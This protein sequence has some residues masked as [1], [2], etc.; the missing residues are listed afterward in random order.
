MHWLR[1]PS[2]QGALQDLAAGHGP[3]THET[4]DRLQPYGTV[5]LIRA[6]L[7]TAGAIPPRDEQL[8]RLEDQVLRIAARV[9]DPG[10]RR[11]VRSFA[12]WHHLRRLRRRSQPASYE[13]INSARTE[14]KAAAELVNWLRQHGTTLADCRQHDIDEWLTGTAWLRVLARTFLAWAV[15]NRH[16]QKVKIPARQ[17]RLSGA[18][19]HTDKRWNL[20]RRLLHD[21]TLD[22]RDRVAGLILL[23]FAQP[24]TRISTLTIDQIDD[25]GVLLTLTLGAEPI[26]IPPPLDDLLRA[27]RDRRQGHAA[28]GRTDSNPWLFPGGVPGGHLSSHQLQRNMKALGVHAR[29]ARNTSLIDLAADLPAVVLSQLLDLHLSTA[30]RWTATAGSP[31]ADYAADLLRRADR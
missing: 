19:I 6:A 4:L 9:I 7:V 12:T 26:Q 27:L 16:A 18:G 29:P 17:Q 28:I 10:D 2:P 15:R 11:T 30:T 22:L 3:V 23:L 5:R 24:L 21:D 14:I 8:A 1:N 20:I 13:Q 25:D 31:A